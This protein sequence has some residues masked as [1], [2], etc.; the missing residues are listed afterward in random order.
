MV[1]SV[2]GKNNRVFHNGQKVNDQQFGDG[3][4]DRLEEQGFLEAIPD[5]ISVQQ[6]EAVRKKETTINDYT[7]LEIMGKLRQ[8]EVKF[9]NDES[10]V[11]LY[12][13]LKKV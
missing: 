1:D 13:R 10:K 7:R 6:P 8:A 5:D 11:V 2:T 9:S 3:L 4:A 12:D